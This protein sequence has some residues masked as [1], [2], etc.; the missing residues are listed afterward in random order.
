M[1]NL[2]ELPSYYSFFVYTP[3]DL[4]NTFLKFRE[5]YEIGYSVYFGSVRVDIVFNSFFKPLKYC[6]LKVYSREYNFIR[7]YSVLSRVKLKGYLK[8]DKEGS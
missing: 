7:V 3:E 8:L 5:V 6:S 4:S 1:L 2:E